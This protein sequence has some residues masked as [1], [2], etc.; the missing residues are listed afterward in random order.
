M[1][2]GPTSSKTENVSHT[3]T[4]IGIRY[5]H[6][7]NA[8]PLYFIMRSI[9]PDSDAFSPKEHPESRLLLV[10]LGFHTWM[11]GLVALLEQLCSRVDTE[12]GVC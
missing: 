12:Q 4:N 10:H 1:S 11:L 8:F 6:R 3:H 2:L 9:P 7:C 5:V